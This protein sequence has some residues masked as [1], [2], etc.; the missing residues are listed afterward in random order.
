M[1]L[2]RFEHDGRALQLLIRDDGAIGALLNE[3][4][5]FFDYANP[6]EALAHVTD[7]AWKCTLAQFRG[8]AVQ[9]QDLQSRTGRRLTA[10]NAGL[11]TVV[12]E[13]GINAVL[14]GSRHPAARACRRWLCS[15][16][17]PAIARTGTYS[18]A[19]PLED[20]HDVQEL[21]RQHV[22]ASV[23][24]N[25]VVG[26]DDTWYHEREIGDVH[27]YKKP[28][29]SIMHHARQ[30]GPDSW[31]YLH[32]LQP[33]CPRFQRKWRVYRKRVLVRTL[34][35]GNKRKTKGLRRWALNDALPKGQPL[36]S[37]ARRGSATLA[38]ALPP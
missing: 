15:E 28:R 1:A 14:L 36:R 9:P 4:A 33:D 30:A 16:V 31:R 2:C 34:L 5:D 3:L 29:D 32:E 17:M 10:Y 6:R 26:A 37:Q 38:R 25:P 12:L 7:P 19:T 11:Q 23:C 35:R 18:V 21:I 20:A 8:G 22:S 13:H 27:E 24:L